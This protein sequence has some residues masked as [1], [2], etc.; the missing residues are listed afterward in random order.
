MLITKLLVIK[1]LAFYSIKSGLSNPWPYT[2]ARVILGTQVISSMAKYGRGGRG[3][4]HPV[5]HCYN[6]LL[7]TI[8][9]VFDENSIIKVS[10]SCKVMSQ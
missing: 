2:A 8:G 10:I 1:V 5:T 3:S 4:F 7:L 9:T 6:K